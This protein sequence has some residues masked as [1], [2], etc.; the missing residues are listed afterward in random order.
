MANQQTKY[1]H[2][3]PR[4]YLKNFS[5]TGHNLFKKR[6]V[7]NEDKES[8]HR[9]LKKPISLKKA[10]V[11]EDFYTVISSKDPMLVENLIYA[12]EIEERYPKIYQL[13]IDEKK[14]GFDM[15]ERNWILICLL[16]LHCRTPRQ[17]KLFEENI[18]EE[19]KYEID[20]INE[21]YKAAHVKETLTKF[22]AAHQLKRVIIAKLHSNAEFITSDNPLLIIGEGNT[23]K[24]GNFKEQ[25]NSENLIF[26]PLDKKHC[27]IL[28]HAKD[29]NGIRADNKLFYNRIERMDANDLDPNF[30]TN[31]NTLTLI[32]AENYC[33][34]SEKYLN[35]F[36]NFFYL[37]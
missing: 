10:T 1:Q 36:F 33:F 12:N 14:D 31:I 6:K 22:I 18:P 23:I 5:D 34:G 17:F 8:I 26:I 20:K 16:S 19:Y 35:A 24:N 30:A 9:D 21:D 15:M 2:T 3:V 37:K 7:F 28:A 29:K 27:F 4:C 32:N 11:I 13:L 25:F